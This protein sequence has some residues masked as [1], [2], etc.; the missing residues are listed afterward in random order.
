MSPSRIFAI[1]PI[2]ALFPG[3][4]NT[5]FC[6]GDFWI[7]TG[8]P[9]DSI[10]NS[11]VVASNGHVCAATNNGVHASTD[12]GEHWALIGLADSIVA[13]VGIRADDQVLAG[14]SGDFS[15]SLFRTY[16]EGAHWITITMDTL[17][18]YPPP[19]QCL[20]KDAAGYLYAG[21]FFVYRVSLRWLSPRMR[22]FTSLLYPGLRT[23]ATSP[24]YP[25]WTR[26]STS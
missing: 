21:G 20:A 7:R 14:T 2:V 1:I 8:G 23:H 15:G 19:V 22:S 10:V 25:I 16:D 9:A 5:A 13:S 4:G 18:T 3:A 11:I 6:Q 12:R 24:T 17:P 26:G